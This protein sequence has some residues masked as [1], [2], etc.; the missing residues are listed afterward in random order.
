MKVNLHFENVGIGDCLLLNLRDNGQEFT[1]LIDCGKY[2]SKIKELFEKT[3][4]ITK[5]DK[6]VITHFDDDR[7]KGVIELL[8]DRPELKIEDIWFNCFRHLPKDKE[9]ELTEFQKIKIE[10]LYSELGS[11]YKPVEANISAE[12]SL[13]LSNILSRNTNWSSSWSDERISIDNQK[14]FDLGQWGKIHLLSPTD[15]EINELE[16]LYKLEFCK[17]LYG[18][19][20]DYS[21][22]QR[23]SIYELL[24][25]TFEDRDTEFPEEEYPISSKQL[26]NK[27]AVENYS[28]TVVKI[29]DNVTNRSS[30]AFIWTLHNHKVLFLGDSTPDI[31]IKYIQLYK[32]V[33]GIAGTPLLFDA[34]KV[35]HHGSKRNMT[36][37]LLH[38]IDS[39]VFIFCGTS[40]LRPDEICISKV[41]SRKLPQEIKERKLYFNYQND[42]VKNFSDNKTIQKEFA[43][44]IIIDSKL[45]I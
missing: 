32:E 26:L 4:K 14:E 38:E 40:Q 15:N 16:N 19:A 42:I 17:K 37:E 28:N 35:S 31:V 20:D 3:Y 39:E 8:K 23:N 11:K 29:D 43:F 34:I 18:K 45:E 30:I 21:S 41:I 36:N 13:S 33:N 1:M 22:E 7:I 6:L 2:N 5:L 9:I 12:Q 44:S 10:E 27:R 25:R 24:L